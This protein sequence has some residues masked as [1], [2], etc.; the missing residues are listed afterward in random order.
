MRKVIGIAESMKAGKAHE[1]WPA[2]AWLGSASSRR[3]TKIFRS[4]KPR[5]HM[6]ACGQ[7][8]AVLGLLT[9]TYDPVQLPEPHSGSFDSPTRPRCSGIT[10]TTIQLHCKP[11]HRDTRPTPNRVALNMLLQ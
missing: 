6:L 1:G 7:F 10:T 4:S 3:L 5:L 8:I 9:T 2:A 11:L